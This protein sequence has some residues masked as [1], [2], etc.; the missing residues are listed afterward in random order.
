LAKRY[1]AQ[2]GG[3]SAELFPVILGSVQ[4]IQGLIRDL[5]D[6]SH[7]V[8]RSELRLIDLD[9]N[10]L[11]DQV[12]FVCQAA[13]QDSGAVATRDPLPVVRADEAQLAQ[14]LQNL[15]SNAI[16]YRRPDKPPRVHLSADFRSD[17]WL[18]QV[19]DNG[20]GFDPQYSERIF[21]LFKRLH[22]QGEY[23]GS[24]IG[25]AICRKIIERH[26]GRI[27]AESE[28]GHGARFFFTLRRS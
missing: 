15:I 13:I 10:M 22:G 16:K 5:L 3:E 19:T 17:E 26:G 18:F 14:V 27:W 11:L 6:Y 9:C 8:H 4:R 12:L 28:A 24:G 1:E 2:N 25:L 23:S 7:I 20:I 21:G